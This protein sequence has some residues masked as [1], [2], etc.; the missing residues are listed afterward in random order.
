MRGLSGRKMVASPGERFSY[1][2]IAYNVLGDLLAKV[3][4]QSFERLIQEHILIPAG[5]PDSTFL[6]DRLPPIGWRC[7]TCAHPKCGSTTLPVPP[8]RCTRQLPA[9]HRC[10]MCRWAITCLKQGSDA[11][12]GLLSPAGYD[13]CGRRWQ[14]GAASVPAS[15]STWGWAGRWGISKM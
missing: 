9:H 8:G 7:R 6:S 1:S 15:M 14:N 13:R 12:R 11:G 3:S 2:N 4:G 10:G 5:M